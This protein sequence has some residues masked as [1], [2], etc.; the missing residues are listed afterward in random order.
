MSWYD[1]Q[2]SKDLRKGD[3]PFYSFIMAAISKADTTNAAKL[4]AVWPE[5]Y[6]EFEKRYNGPAGFILP[7]EADDLSRYEEHLNRKREE[8]DV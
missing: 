6:E 2:I 4:K 7:E 8:S 3:P 5:V 1:Y